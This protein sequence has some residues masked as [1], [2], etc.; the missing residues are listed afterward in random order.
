M[1]APLYNRI[2]ELTASY[3]LHMPGHKRRADFLPQDI[4]SLDITEIE[5]SDNL[6][7]PKDVI[8]QAQQ[9]LARLYGADES[10][11]CV[12]GGSSGILAAVLGTCKEGETLLTVRNAHKSL[13]N[14]LIL[15]GAGAVY[16]DTPVSSYGFALP[17]KAE[18]IESAIAANR[19]IKAVFIVSPTYEGF[20][21]D[22]GKIAEITHKYGKIL[23]VD[24]TH[25]AHFPFNAA[26]PE[27]AVNRGADI[28]VNSWHKTLPLPNQCAVMNIKTERVDVKRIKQA[29]SMVTT[30]S[31]SYIFMGLTDYVRA[32]YEENPQIFDRYA[33]S[34]QS[35]R[36]KLAGLKNLALADNVIKGY[37]FDISKLTI[38]RKC[39]ESMADIAE[40][41]KNGGFELELAG[42]KHLIA[43]TSAADDTDMLNKFADL[44][45]SIDKSL[46]HENAENIVTP[47]NG[48]SER[49]VQRD[50]FYA[51]KE[52][53]LLE[54]AEGR[55]AA[56]FV[57]PFPPDIPLILAGEKITK[58]HIEEIKKMQENGTEILGITENR[59]WVR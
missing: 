19:G 54:N 9:R 6:H 55:T 4:L 23:M 49:G 7:A 58:R 24:E 31:P 11:I 33:E 26:F 35:I 46:T 14:A 56:D 22:V 53:I 20:C 37:E 15:C 47:A 45:L 30:T 50:V 34:L 29:F 59:L 40:M 44:L 25:G 18:N 43:M 57:T 51:D 2:R 42:E 3:P 27:N 52:E 10:I 17:V 16:I 48:S 5:G 12:N 38:L 32:Y 1:D 21:A 13:Q 39:R 41:L 8:M 36:K 28:S